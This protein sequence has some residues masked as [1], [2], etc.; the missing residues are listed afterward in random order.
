L[1]E[2]LGPRRQEAFKRKGQRGSG[3]WERFRKI[4]LLA[5]RRVERRHYRQRL[6]LMVYEKNRQ[7]ILKDLGA[8]PY[9]D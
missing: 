1:L 7:E 8:D 5:Q 3:L 2:G 4:F 9:V 6:D